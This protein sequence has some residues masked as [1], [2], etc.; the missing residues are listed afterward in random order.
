MHSY[1]NTY[2]DKVMSLVVSDAPDGFNAL[3]T[4][5]PRTLVLR[6]GD[7]VARTEPASTEVV[8]SGDAKPVDYK[9]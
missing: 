3:R 7:P 5:A 1:N 2:A 6:D 4:Q 9:Q 8:R